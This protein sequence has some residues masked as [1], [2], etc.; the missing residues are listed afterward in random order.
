M[1]LTAYATDILDGEI[2]HRFD[3]ESSFGRYVLDPA[4]DSAMLAAASLGAV[5]AGRIPFATVVAVTIAGVAGQIVIM[6]VDDSRVMRRIANGAHPIGY[7][8]A[9]VYVGGV[10]VTAAGVPAH[11]AWPAALVVAGLVGI[12]KRR[13]L[14][15]WLHGREF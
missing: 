12:L 14:S 7:C 6:V 11:K 3:G 9:T 13:R 10:Y 1:L 15:A 5:A 2:A 4:C 8:V